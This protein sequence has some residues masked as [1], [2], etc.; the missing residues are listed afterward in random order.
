MGATKPP[1]DNPDQDDNPD[2]YPSIVVSR[3]FFPDSWI[4][5]SWRRKRSR[6]KQLGVA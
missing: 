4:P 6:R 2:L 1:K 3:G 5:E